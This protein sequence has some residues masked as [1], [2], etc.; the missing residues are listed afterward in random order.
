MENKE[1]SRFE[2][3]EIVKDSTSKYILVSVG[4]KRPQLISQ[5]TNLPDL[6]MCTVR[7]VKNFGKLVCDSAG[8]KFNA[9]EILKISAILG[10]DA[11][12]YNKMIND[13]WVYSKNPSGLDIVSNPTS[14]YI[15]WNIMKEGNQGIIYNA[16][17]EVIMRVTLLMMIELAKGSDSAE[18]LSKES[19]QQ[20]AFSLAMCVIKSL[21]R[22]GTVNEKK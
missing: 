21:E 12:I 4:G 14:Q 13:L 10:N 16:E 5:N 7:M 2:A 3:M 8:T 15:L 17:Q 20:S 18:S 22:E 11:M 1:M 6:L 9:T 19:M